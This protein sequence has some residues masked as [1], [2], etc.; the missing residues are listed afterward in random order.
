MAAIN[1]IFFVTSVDLLGDLYGDDI[2][3]GARYDL[4]DQFQRRVAHYVPVRVPL[5][6][7]YL[8]PKKKI[9]RWCRRLRPTLLRYGREI[10]CELLHLPVPRWFL[11]S[12]TGQTREDVIH[13]LR[14][15]NV[16]ELLGTDSAGDVKMEIDSYMS[17]YRASGVGDEWA[18]WMPTDDAEYGIAWCVR[19]GAMFVH[20][21]S[22][23]GH[24]GYFLSGSH[25][26][27]CKD[28]TTLHDLLAVLFEAL[29]LR[30]SI[31]SPMAL[32]R[33]QNWL[34]K[35]HGEKHLANYLNLPS[36][37]PAYVPNRQGYPYGC[38]SHSAWIA[39]HHR[40]EAMFTALVPRAPSSAGS[41]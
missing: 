39:S 27:L 25:T 6:R 9:F 30:M 2:A 22:G 13:V 18:R 15:D 4:L 36:F 3:R 14:V 19:F 24:P 35:I 31:S 1:R 17:E 8:C 26:N 10:A 28:A 29:E 37:P 32:E 7:S 21:S 5:L 12:H 34:D 23:A 16:L 11:T 41:C 40:L 20:R 38:P 33:L